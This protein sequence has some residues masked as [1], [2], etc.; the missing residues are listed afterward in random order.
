MP[1]LVIQNTQQLF[2][3]T[4]I[5]GNPD[6]LFS[7]WQA[8]KEY[9]FQY[10]QSFIEA[11][12]A[13]S[14]DK[15]K[16]VCFMAP[17]IDSNIRQAVRAIKTAHPNIAVTIVTPMYQEPFV[18]EMLCSSN[19]GPCVDDYIVS[20]A[21]HEEFITMLKKLTDLEKPEI[22]EPHSFEQL[23]RLA[24]EDDLTGLKNRRYVREF[25][26]QI[27][28][29]AQASSLRIT[30]LMFD[31]DDFKHYNDVYGHLAGDEILKEA[32]A[33]MRRCCRK[34]DIVGR[35]GGDEFAVI[36]WD[37]P[38]ESADDRR[39][40]AQADHPSEIYF[41]ADRF[42]RELNSTQ[43]PQLGPE[44]KGILTISG[45]LAGYPQ[46]GASVEE[47]FASADRALLEAKRLGKNRIYL[48]GEPTID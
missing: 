17:E 41:I 5:L 24:T 43:F 1:K 9:P 10:S 32:A 40:K 8:V 34:H 15:C 45:G 46:D 37:N 12:S 36:F 29:Q 33:L 7:D 13:V 18:L 31:I 25:L 16:I 35:I 20:P 48:I 3:S 2:R 47:L 14:Q 11:L 26:R 44:G 27:L 22:F 28:D 38:T 42:R 19:N 23:A 6:T 39:R 21:G 30:L 4:L